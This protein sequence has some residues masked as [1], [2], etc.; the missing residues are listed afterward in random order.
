MHFGHDV[1]LQQ[2][3]RVKHSLLQDTVQEL[4]GNFLRIPAFL[5][6][7]KYYN[8]GIITDF[9]TVGNRFNRVFIRFPGSDY[10][11]ELSLPWTGFDGTWLKLCYKQTLLLAV[12][13]DGNNK[14]SIYSM[15]VVES[16]NNDS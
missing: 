4:E 5:E 14:T 6:R 8:L 11:F 13:R 10:L 1:L 15:A 12:G 2:C 9:Q 7:L 3:T 16:E